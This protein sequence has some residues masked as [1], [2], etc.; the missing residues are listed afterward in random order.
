MKAFNRHLRSCLSYTLGDLGPLVASLLLFVWVFRVRE[1]E[2]FGAFAVAQAV[3]MWLQP[4]VGMAMGLT[5]PQYLAQFPEG[6]EAVLAQLTRVRL[7]VALLVGVGLAAVA[8]ACPPLVGWTLLATIPLLI[9]TALQQ[10]CGC[11]GPD[12]AKVYRHSYWLQSL[13]PLPLVALVCTQQLHPAWI[14]LMQLL[15]TTTAVV[16][17]W[18]GLRLSLRHLRLPGPLELR[19]IG[20]DAL[21]TTGAQFM[22]CGFHCVDLL[23]LGWLGAANLAQLG[24]YRLGSRLITLGAVVLS[25][26]LRALSGE[27]AAAYAQSPGHVKRLERTTRSLQLGLGAAGA[28]LI[29]FVAPPLFGFIAQRPLP[30]LEAIAPWIG[31]AFFG[32]A[33]QNSYLSLLPYQG[34]TGAYALF[35]TARLLVGLLLCLLLIPIW[36]LVGAAAAMAGAMYL[37]VGAGYLYQRTLIPQAA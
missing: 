27:L 13:L 10:D 18:R 15:G 20:R 37:L 22:Q 7:A 21:Y 26:A 4:L 35:H 36:Q 34:R 28:L 17:Q 25:A 2:A 12:Q 5:A 33:W 11:V 14:F 1:P 9:T 19:R 16:W 32:L 24:E 30:V 3:L 6:R 23:L 29:L 8:L 31:A